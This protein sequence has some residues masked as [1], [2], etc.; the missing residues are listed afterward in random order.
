[1]NGRNDLDPKRTVTV[2]TVQTQLVY[3]E[4]ESDDICRTVDAGPAAFDPSPQVSFEL[5]QPL[6]IGI[7]DHANVVHTT[8]LTAYHTH[9]PT[10]SS[11]THR[12]NLAPL[13]TLLCPAS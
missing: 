13:S 11:T 4:F 3:E 9:S 12:S 6:R 8:I 7:N 2:H 1:M 5:L 10:S